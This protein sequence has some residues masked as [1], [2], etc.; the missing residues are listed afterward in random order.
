M[1]GGDIDWPTLAYGTAVEGGYY[2][3]RYTLNGVTY[4]LIVAPKAAGEPSLAIKTTTTV[5]DGA[6]SVIDGL[7][8]T[9]AMIAAGSAAHP[10]ASFCRNLSISG[11]TDWYL[12]A[13]LEMEII[14][15]N[16]KPTTTSNEP[17]SNSPYNEPNGVNSYSVPAGTQ[18]TYSN[19]TVTAA[20]EFV[21]GKSEAFQSS[22]YWSSTRDGR[23][24]GY[25]VYPRA[26]TS[27][28]FTSTGVRN[29]RLVRAVRRVPITGA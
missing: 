14:Y 7:A 12:P 18:Y 20:A 10:A 16:L 28:D 8:N 17:I 21:S 19:P 25:N 4:A 5:T 13:H 1:A 29:S 11:F 26:M 24:T 23:Y 6:G 3:G 22:T 27:G 15:R 9:N 2:A